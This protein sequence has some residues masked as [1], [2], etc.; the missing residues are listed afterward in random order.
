MTIPVPRADGDE[1]GFRSR[2]RAQRGSIRRF[3]A[4]MRRHVDASAERIWPVEH[5]RE[6][7]VDRVAGEE[8]RKGPAVDSQHE[9]WHIDGEVIGREHAD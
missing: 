4:V 9:R 1:R 8:R 6:R 7:V 2:R 3:G 5:A